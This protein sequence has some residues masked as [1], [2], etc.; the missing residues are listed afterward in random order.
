MTEQLWWA[1]QAPRG[2][3]DLSVKGCYGR[4]VFEDKE[5]FGGF[6]EEQGRQKGF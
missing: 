6:A 1:E 2:E 3:D 4:E 5:L